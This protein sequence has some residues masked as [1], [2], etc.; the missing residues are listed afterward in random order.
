MLYIYLD[1]I[2]IHIYL[3]LHAKHTS[4]GFVMLCQVEG[5]AAGVVFRI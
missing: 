1:Y 5:F 4:Y 2:Y 3:Y